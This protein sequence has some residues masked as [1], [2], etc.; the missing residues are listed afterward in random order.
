[1]MIQ[2]QKSLRKRQPSGCCR[3]LQANRHRHPL[4]LQYGHS[5]SQTDQHHLRGRHVHE[6]GSHHRR[7]CRWFR[8]L[9][10]GLQ[11]HVSPGFRRHG[12]LN[13]ERTSREVIQ[14][15]ETISHGCETYMNRLR[16]TSSEKNTE[17]AKQRIGLQTEMIGVI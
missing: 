13:G 4:Q 2:I 9:R 12:R 6:R 15:W 17:Q 10:S 14:R 16:S 11:H 1:M 7:Q 8:Q 3:C 5:V